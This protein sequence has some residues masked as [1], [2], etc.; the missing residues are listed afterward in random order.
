MADNEMD[1]AGPMPG[2]VCRTIIPPVGNVRLRFLIRWPRD[3]HLRRTDGQ[4]MCRHVKDPS[5]EKGEERDRLVDRCTCREEEEEEEK[6]GQVRGVLRFGCEDSDPVPFP[7]P[8]DGA[9]VLQ[10]ARHR[11]RRRRT[12]PE[13][14][15][16]PTLPASA[17]A[18]HCRRMDE[19]RFDAVAEII[20]YSV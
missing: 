3:D 2:Q 11:F 19:G 14:L 20:L 15:R 6:H 7:L 5:R 16:H 17:D 4:P 1:R 9:H 10:A 13:A 8:P 18:P 12:R